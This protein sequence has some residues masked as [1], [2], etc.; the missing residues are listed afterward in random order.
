MLLRYPVDQLVSV[1]SEM[2]YFL[3]FTLHYTQT[4]P[5]IIILIPSEVRK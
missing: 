3:Q 4:V 5:P 2:K 1:H